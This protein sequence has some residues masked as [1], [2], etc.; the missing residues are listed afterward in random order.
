MSSVNKSLSDFSH[1]LPDGSALRVGIVCADWNKNIT[2]SLLR[3]AES[4]LE[5]AG[6]SSKNIIVAYV[7][8]T[9]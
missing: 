6:V 9:F 5:K 8:G 2:G 7:P 1:P 4:I 3:G